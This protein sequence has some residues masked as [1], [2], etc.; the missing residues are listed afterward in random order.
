[1]RLLICGALSNYAIERYYLQYLKQMDEVE[2]DILAAQN[3]FLDYYNQSIAH[4][5]LFRLGYQKIY[6]HI[7]KQLLEKVDVFNPDV[8]F[9]F[10]G[11]E[12]F[13]ET[14]LKIRNKGVRLLNYN[15]DN[16]FVFSGKGSGN[17]NITKSISL[18]H[19]H[20]T[21]DPDI[22]KQLQQFPVKA[23]LLPFGFDLSVKD[24]EEIKSIIEIN[25]ICFLGNPD[26]DRAK[27]IQEVSQHMPVEI[28]GNKWNK[29]LNSNANLT[30]KPPVY[31]LEFWKVL[32]QYR[33]QLNLMRPHNPLSHNMRSFEVP[34]VGGIGMFPDTPDHRKYFA[35]GKE[36]VIY[37]DIKDCIKKCLWL[38]SISKEDADNLRDQARNRSLLSN[39]CYAKRAEEIM[40]HI[41]VL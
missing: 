38:L 1:M 11:M 30:I 6:E 5:I 9:V 2:V 27:F 18:Y 10:K 37:T 13:P 22:L 39:Y 34:A 40:Q 16:P 31:G 23:K 12:I 35:S 32:R 28:Y 15:P 14:L 41:K 17:S 19:L 8:I 33:V 25:K 4:K 7:N 21:Y 26:K 20:F 36:I 29:F 24:F 3:I